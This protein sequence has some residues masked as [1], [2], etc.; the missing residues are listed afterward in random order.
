[1]LPNNGVNSLCEVGVFDS[2]RKGTQAH[3]RGP[4]CSRGY[5]ELMIRRPVGGGSATDTSA[6]T[7][8]IKIDEHQTNPPGVH[9]EI[10]FVN[11]LFA[12]AA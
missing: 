9:H 12:V 8:R 3:R 7:L 1:M 6:Q 2:H 5:L 10:R 11:R 4:K